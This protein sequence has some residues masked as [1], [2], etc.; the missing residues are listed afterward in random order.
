[1]DTPLKD[2]HTGFLTC[3]HLLG[4]LVVSKRLMWDSYQESL[5]YLAPEQRL[6]RQLSLCLSPSP[7]TLQSTDHSSLTVQTPLIGPLGSSVLRRS[8]SPIQPA[9]CP[10]LLLLNDCHTLYLLRA[11]HSQLAGSTGSMHFQD[12]FRHIIATS[13]NFGGYWGP[14][15]ST[16]LQLFLL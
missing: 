12:S 3:R 8:A 9:D 5:H 14:R 10:G 16:I 15:A 4:T 2:P 13:T 6:G 11:K 7:P 1:M